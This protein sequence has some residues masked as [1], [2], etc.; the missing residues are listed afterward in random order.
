MV[1]VG[2]EVERRSVGINTL[3]RAQMDLYGISIVGCCAS[4]PSTNGT[5]VHNLFSVALAAETVLLVR[6]FFWGGVGW[7]GCA[8]HS[9]TTLKKSKHTSGTR[10]ET[11]ICLSGKKGLSVWFPF[12]FQ[13]TS[14]VSV[15]CSAL[16][17]WLFSLGF[18]LTLMVNTEV[19]DKC[20][21]KVQLILKSCAEQTLPDLDRGPR[22]TL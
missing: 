13:S 3:W 9:R 19:T 18:S 5:A 11:W 20:L 15:L 7:V 10:C 2:P 1:W 21:L 16:R 8:I 22:G 4:L 12:L 17:Y 14:L 6:S